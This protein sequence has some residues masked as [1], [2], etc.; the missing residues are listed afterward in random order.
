MLK[1]TSNP[2]GG[3]IPEILLGMELDERSQL[4][5]A[6]GSYRARKPFLYINFQNDGYLPQH[7]STLMRLGYL[8]QELYSQYRENI[9]ALAF[10]RTSLNYIAHKVQYL[11]PL[12]DEPRVVWSQW[13]GNLPGLPVG[14]KGEYSADYLARHAEKKI[15]YW[16]PN[17]PMK[18]EPQERKLSLAVDEWLAYLQIGDMVTA[19]RRGKLGVALVVTIDGE[20]RDLTSVGVGLVKRCH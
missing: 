4:F 15:K 8:E 14:V 18:G 7:T 20:Q 2:V 9:E 10:L 16:P 5:D 3:S 12:R 13:T 19:K 17:S 1:E 6:L 11:G